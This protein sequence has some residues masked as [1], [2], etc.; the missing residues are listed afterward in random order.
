MPFLRIIELIAH[1]GWEGKNYLMNAGIILFFEMNID[2][3]KK[4]ARRSICFLL[5]EIVG[6]DRQMARVI[7]ERP[8]LITNLAVKF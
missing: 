6:C 5:G 4:L 3:Y 8:E 2:C 7:F 1:K